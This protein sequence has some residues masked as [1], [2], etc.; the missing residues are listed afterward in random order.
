MKHRFFI[1]IV[2]SLFLCSCNAEE[3][4]SNLEYSFETSAQ[5]FSA[6]VQN[7]DVH[8]FNAVANPSGIYLVRKF[9][10]GNLGGRGEELSANFSTSSVTEDMEFLVND[11][12]PFSLKL[13][14]PG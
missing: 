7:G 3:E 4:S 6:A 10:S 14:F 13:V 5:L 11:Q 8:K 2:I 1:G 12:T 9:T